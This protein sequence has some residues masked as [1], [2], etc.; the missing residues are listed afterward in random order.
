L[1]RKGNDDID[2]I[3]DD[4]FSNHFKGLPVRVFSIES[5]VPEYRN[6]KEKEKKSFRGGFWKF[7]SFRFHLISKHMK[8]NNL[9]NIIHVEND[10][11]VYRKLELD[12]FHT[13]DKILLT[14]DHPNRCIPGFMFIPSHH[15]MEKCVESFDQ[16]K[17]D[18]DNWALCFKRYS[19]FIDTLPIF[20]TD[21]N[22]DKYNSI[23][24]AAAI[25][26]YLGGVDPRNIPGD[27]RGFVN[28]TCVVKY[29]KYA[30]SS[31]DGVPHI[32]IDERNIPI[33]NLHIHSKDLKSFS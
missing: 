9:E 19:E 33:N 11:L 23:F 7:T 22:F 28:E 15:I 2:V 30:F 18:M 14:I 29:N 20:V 8:L 16:T 21:K 25:G 31:I 10:V 24:D 3:C 6:I 5:L 12:M 1:A 26:Q 17:N 27:T 32:K 4:E 13:H